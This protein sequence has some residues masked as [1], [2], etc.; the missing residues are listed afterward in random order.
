MSK[1]LRNVTLTAKRKTESE[2]IRTIA[3]HRLNIV[4]G[5]PSQPNQCRNAI[6][7]ALLRLSGQNGRW[8][9][10]SVRWRRSG[11]HYAS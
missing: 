10:Q 4:Y 2:K 11:R 8:A 9:V 3:P 5:S 1:F 6:M 7:R